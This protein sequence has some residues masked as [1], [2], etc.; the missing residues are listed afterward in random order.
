MVFLPLKNAL[1]EYNISSGKGLE[2][3]HFDE[4]NH[5]IDRQDGLVQMLL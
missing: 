5:K 3:L 2:I 1:D 4:A